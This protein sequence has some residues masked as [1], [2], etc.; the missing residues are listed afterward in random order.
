MKRLICRKQPPCGSGFTSLSSL[1]KW[2]LLPEEKWRERERERKAGLGLNAPDGHCK[3]WNKHRAA[4]FTLIH[5]GAP[6]VHSHRCN[7]EISRHKIVA[8]IAK[9]S[10]SIIR[11]FCPLILVCCIGEIS[12]SFL[13]TNYIS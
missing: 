13:E 8:M 9:G 12:L 11:R 6:M 7:Y 10:A 3:L 5:P 4:E 2:E 1:E